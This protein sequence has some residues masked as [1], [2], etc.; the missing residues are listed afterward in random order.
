[1]NASLATRMDQRDEDEKKP[2]KSANF[3]FTI[4]RF[5]EA[6]L[7]WVGQKSGW[8]HIGLANHFSH[9]ESWQM[10]CNLLEVQPI[11]LSE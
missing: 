1:M 5:G 8:L 4:Q 9:F 2:E 10:V 7:D 3:E 11:L 6:N